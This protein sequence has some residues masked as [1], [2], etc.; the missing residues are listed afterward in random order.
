MAEQSA[1]FTL[2]LGG[3]AAPVSAEMAD[4][5][6]K[7]RSK[8]QSS[9][10]AIRAMGAA[11][12]SLRGSSDEVKS[13]K[14]QLRA[15]IEG[16]RNAI[17]A[18]SLALLKQ[19]TTYDKLTEA[20]KKARAEKE[21]LKAKAEAAAAEKLKAEQEALTRGIKAAGGPVASLVEGFESLKAVMGTAGGAAAVVAAGLA[22]VAAVAVGV[23]A[24]IVAM[25]V[26]FVRWVLEAGNA[27]RAMALVREAATGT[28]IDALHLGHQ[29]DVLAA[30]VATP[31]EKLNEL[32]ASLTRS[33]S[34][35]M[36][37]GQ[38]IVDTF[39]LVA[40]ASAAMGDEV[41]AQLK[42]IIERGKQFGRIQISPFE[43]QGT[44]ITRDQ[45]A[46][47]L[48]AIMHT[49]VEAARLA[50]AQGTVK[51][52]A[53]AL[54]LRRAVEKRFGEINARKLLDLT[55]IAQKFHEKLAALTADV[56]LEPFLKA[57]EEM[58]HLFDSSTVAGESLKK[59]VTTLGNEIGPAFK[60]LA[61]IAKAAF[62][63]IIIGA[64]RIT[65]AMYQ[66][67]NAIRDAFKGHEDVVTMGDAIKAVTGFVDGLAT[68]FVFT[69]RAITTGVVLAIRAF[70]FLRD[71]AQSVRDFLSNAWDSVGGSIVGGIAAGIT[72]GAGEVVSALRNLATS[73]K[74]AFKRALGIASPSKVF[75][76]EA[77]QIPAGTVQG[78]ESGAP[79]VQGA[80]D[81]MAPTPSGAPPGAPGGRL[82]AGGGVS[83]VVASGAVQIIVQGGGEGAAKALSEPSFLAQL[84][85][86]LTDAMTAAASPTGTPVTP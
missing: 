54:A 49:G 17:S 5:L 57:L 85:K 55:V 41:G 27:Q 10:D 62:K 75:A 56:K 68:A 31:K 18:S 66:M 69:I 32:A 42:A 40:Q 79:A 44:G 11:M 53:A 8:M 63:E 58:T 37:S 39:N 4:E 12:K 26:A 82:G 29:L 30:K 51:V 76:A 24:G 34:G 19:G 73:G 65:I 77:A 71:A 43:L 47:E 60:A 84:T 20:A 83:V 72:G 28:A 35:T 16:E 45:V 59:L 46:K 33:L 6:E 80:A 86:A 2:N 3:D 67:R 64:F 22:A 7:L 50:L 61:P 38:G 78:I 25:T 1:T 74:E 36:V 48:A 15:K 70:F 14:E 81:R 52:D 23:A 21:K 13:A 9:T